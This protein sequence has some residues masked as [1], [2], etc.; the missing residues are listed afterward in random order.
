M[1]HKQKQRKILTSCITASLFL[2]VLALGFLQRYSLWFSSPQKGEQLSP[3]LSEVEKRERDQILKVSF[4]LAEELGAPEASHQPEKETVS[5][6]LS[7][8]TQTSPQDPLSLILFHTSFPTPEL[9]AFPVLPTFTFSPEPINLLEHLPKDL[10]L[11]TPSKQPVAHFPPPAPSDAPIALSAKPPAVPQEAPPP[12]ITYSEP[13][14]SSLTDAPALPKAP[15]PIPLPHLPQFPSLAELETSSYSHCFDADLVFLP[16]EEGGYIFAL[17]LIPRPDL[18]LPKI[19]QHFTFLIDRSNS[20][21]QERLNMTKSAIQKAIREL[22][23]DDTFN[24]IAFDNKIE[25]MAPLPLPCG[26]KSSAAAEVFLDKIQLGSFFSSSDIYKPLFLTVPA[27]A[28]SDEIHTAILLTDGEAFAKKQVSRSILHDWTQFNGGRVGLYALG[29]NGDPHT[30]TLDA[31]TT[32]NR[33][34]LTSAPTSRGL[35]RKLLKLI[36]TIHAPIAK[37]LSCKAISRSSHTKVQLYPQ[38][39]QTPPLY[40]DQPYVI[41][42]EADALDDFILFVQGRIKDRWINIKKTVSFVNAKKGSKSLK[43]EWALQRAYKLYERYA[44][45]DNP[46]HIAEAEAILEPYDFEVAFK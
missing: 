11:P 35:K 22:S 30:A 19:R 24:I 12:L 17:T 40:L 45:D 25:K 26:E 21:Q 28:E 33:G 2:H 23:P 4:E 38:S 18:D 7:S 41:L 6:S 13:I 43:K 9:L 20:I 32:F 46:Q 1:N 14:E 44:R 8:P 34:K 3:W 39:S 31:A 36:K 10:I 27:R 5:L 15:S 37:N 29:L 16:R 42:G